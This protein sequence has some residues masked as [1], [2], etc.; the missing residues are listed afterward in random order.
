M[1]GNGMCSRCANS[2]CCSR[3]C[4]G[5]SCAPDAQI[6]EIARAI[7]E[8]A[9]LRRAP[10]GAGDRIPAVRARPA[11]DAGGRIDVEHRVRL[12]ER[13]EID[14]PVR[15]IEHEPRHSEADEMIRRSVVD[16]DGEVDR[17]PIDAHETP[18]TFIAARA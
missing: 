9:R 5:E 7:T 11:W 13:G 3:D 1:T 18:Q 6:R 16:G 4:T 15:R 12:R 17:K 2:I 8:R 10:A 14:R